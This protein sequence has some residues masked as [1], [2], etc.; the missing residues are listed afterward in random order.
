MPCPRGA[1]TL[2]HPTQDRPKVPVE[3]AVVD[4]FEGIDD[5][6]ELNAGRERLA[7]PANEN[8]CEDKARRRLNEARFGETYSI[9]VEN[10]NEV[11]AK[12]GVM[13]NAILGQRKC[14]PFS[15]QIGLCSHG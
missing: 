14:K 1:H 11:I 15:G 4:G 10:P 12:L 8:Q 13:A 7:A 6:V 3:D 5:S 2:D 9:E